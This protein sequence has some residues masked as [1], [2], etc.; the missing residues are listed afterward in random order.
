[1]T[2]SD[3]I[4]NGRPVSLR[5]ATSSDLGAIRLLLAE[6]LLPEAGL[7]EWWPH[8]TVAE[9]DGAI[10]GLAGVERY[11]DGIL[12][13]SVGVHPSW[14]GS[15]LGRVL[16]DTV[17]RKARDDGSQHAYLLTTTAEQYFPRLGFRVIPRTAVPAS[18]QSSIEFREACPATAVAMHRTLA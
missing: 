15:G 8:F 1:M 11:A 12:L 4:L 17:L 6:L 10:V 2:K 13:R 3:Q 18:V 14:R 16:V 5:A 9:S 7:A